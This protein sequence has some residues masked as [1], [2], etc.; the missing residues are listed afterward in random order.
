MKNMYPS[1]LIDKQIKR[2]LHHK[3]SANNSKAVKQTKTTLYYK[4]PYV[5]SFCNNTKEKIKEL[6]KTFCKSSN[7]KIVFSPFK[8]GDLFS[9]NDCL[10][11]DLKSFVVYKFVCT[12]YHS[13]CIGE[14]KRHFPARINEHLVTDKK[15]H[16]FKYLLEN[17]TCKQLCDENCFTI[18]DFAFSSFRLKLKEALHIT[19]LK[20]NLNKQKEH[21]SVTISV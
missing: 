16:I 4:Y 19:W 6:C 21:V 13:S 2:F 3:F 8:T 12:A 5:G 9:S 7:I 18:I 14:N 10:P 15:S 1:Y 20:L 11:I 17:P